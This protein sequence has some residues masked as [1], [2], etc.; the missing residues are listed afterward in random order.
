MKTNTN[1]TLITVAIFAALALAGC[2]KQPKP[3]AAPTA[4]NAA[5]GVT[6]PVADA[7]PAGGITNARPDAPAPVYPPITN[8]PGLIR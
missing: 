8:N 2:G 6:P 4:T 3:Q 5:P 7:P 1:I